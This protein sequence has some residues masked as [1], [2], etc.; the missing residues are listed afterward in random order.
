MYSLIAS[1]GRCYYYC[2]CTYEETRVR[3][4]D[5]PTEHTQEGP[6]VVLAFQL[7]QFGTRLALT[8][9]S[10][11]WIEVTMEILL[12]PYDVIIVCYICCNCLV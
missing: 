7:R 2:H 12:D 9:Y 6:T 5:L 3:K 11:I 1:C 4:D 8:H 10:A